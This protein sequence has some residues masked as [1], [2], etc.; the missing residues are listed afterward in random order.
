MME[1]MEGR[2]EVKKDVYKAMMMRKSN[3]VVAL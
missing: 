3:V 2:E 1:R